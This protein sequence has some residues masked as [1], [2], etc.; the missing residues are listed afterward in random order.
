MDENA[1]YRDLGIA[2]IFLIVGM[3]PSPDVERQDH[4]VLYRHI[5]D[6]WLWQ[7]ANAKENSVHSGIHCSRRNIDYSVECSLWGAP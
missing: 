3:L 5:E 7:E 1:T 6:G 4:A 2:H